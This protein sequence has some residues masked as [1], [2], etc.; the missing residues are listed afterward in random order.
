VHTCLV[1]ITTDAR[2]TFHSEIERE[3]LV[4]ALLS[5]SK[6]SGFQ[7]GNNE[8]SETAIDVKTDIVFEGELTK[9]WNIVLI[10]IWEV[11]CRSNDLT[12]M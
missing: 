9:S 6:P 5:V 1:S 8:A 3:Q 4:V 10:T 11:D 2:N 12:T 7:E